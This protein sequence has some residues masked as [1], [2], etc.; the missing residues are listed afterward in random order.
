MQ[1]LVTSVT[2][3]P[4]RSSQPSAPVIAAQADESCERCKGAGWLRRDVDITHPAFG[5]TVRCD[6]HLD[7]TPAAEARRDRAWRST[8]PERM[9]GFRLATCPNR[10]LANAV[11]TWLAER[12]GSGTNLVIVGGVGRGKTGAAVGA[13]RANLEAGGTIAFWSVP[14]LMDALRFEEFRKS[15]D[16]TPGTL[17]QA[18]RAGLLL[19]DDVG[20]ERP[21]P[22]AQERLHV[23]LAHR[24]D[25]LKPT[26]VT[27]NLNGSS[28]DPEAETLEKYLG[29][30]IASR[31]KQN[32]VSLVAD[33][34]DLRQEGGR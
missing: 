28:D 29:P 12:A 25:R 26:I 16:G 8:V 10:Q 30:R 22:Y 20:T 17:D 34:P 9:T 15:E 32:C 13:L 14:L 7:P 19:L 27:T 11:H 31:L 33:G 1:R 4:F 21:T 6:C 18:F 2:P 3:R 23:L 24:Y 5:Q